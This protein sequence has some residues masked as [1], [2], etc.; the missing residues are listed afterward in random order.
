MDSG[1]TP[2]LSIMHTFRS[3]HIERTIRTIRTQALYGLFLTIFSP[4][5]SIEGHLEGNLRQAGT[6]TPILRYSDTP[7]LPYILLPQF[8]SGPV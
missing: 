2:C 4:S 8:Q 7:T 6:S 3:E 1:H 5:E